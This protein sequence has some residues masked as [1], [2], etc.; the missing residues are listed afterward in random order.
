MQLVG[1]FGFGWGVRLV[2]DEELAR[3]IDARW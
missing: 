3:Y 1:G 2:S